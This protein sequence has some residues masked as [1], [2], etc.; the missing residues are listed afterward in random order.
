MIK[1]SSLAR[2]SF[3]ITVLIVAMH[4]RL[5]AT[6]QSAVDIAPVCNRQYLEACRSL[7]DSAKKAVCI[8]H[9][10]FK[11]DPTT[12]ILRHALERAVNRGVSVRILLEDSIAENAVAVREL[13][14]IGAYAKLDTPST[15]LHTKLIVVDGSSCL[16]GSTN[17]SE[18]SIRSNNE[19]NI[20]IKNSKIAKIYQDYFERAWEDIP[21]DGIDETG[22]APDEVKAVFDRDYFLEALSMIRNAKKKIAVILYMAHFT[23]NFYESRPNRLLRALAEAKRNGVDVRVMVEKSNHDP[24]LNEM[25]EP[26]TAYLRDHGV[27]TRFES[28]EITTHAKLLVC[29]DSVLLGS[30]NWVLSALSHNREANIRIRKK[31]LTQNF[32]DYFEELWSKSGI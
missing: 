32:R 7:I 31:D 19:V 18:Y 14:D 9:F 6:A 4:P 23:P 3:L 2:K 30:T 20:L 24:K 29:D 15:K 5:Y 22:Q 28:P 25:N 10:Y 26:V 21:H 1:I 11:N 13:S 27:Q 12:R 16:L 8:S 17:F